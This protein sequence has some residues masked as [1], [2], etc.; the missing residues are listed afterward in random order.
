MFE[1]EFG[2]SAPEIPEYH[3]QTYVMKGDEYF[4][5]LFAFIRK[6]GKEPLKTINNNLVYSFVK[7]VR[8]FYQLDDWENR[9]IIE[10]S[11]EAKKLEQTLLSRIFIFATVWSVM[12]TLDEMSSIKI[13]QLAVNLFNMNDLPRGSLFDYYLDLTEKENQ[14]V[15]WDS[16]LIEFEYNPTM[17]WSEILVPTIN[18]KRFSYILRRAIKT[19]YPIYLCGITGTGKT[20]L[21]QE[22]SKRDDPSTA[23]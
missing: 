18:T 10:D 6:S 21:C 9:F 22:H 16:M 23:Y 13:D 20:V 4:D 1:T 17:R 2:N 15:K 5:K 19:K 14:W 12:A 8:T 11:E 7:I 3:K